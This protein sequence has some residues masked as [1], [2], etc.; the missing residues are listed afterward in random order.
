VFG[1]AAALLV[2]DLAVHPPGTPL[3][4][5]QHAWTGYLAYAVSFLT[6]GGCVAPADRPVRPIRL[7]RPAVPAA[8]PAPPAR[9]GL[10]P[11]VPARLAREALY[12]SGGER[13]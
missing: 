3:R 2:L 1:S 4:Q 5:A 10:P 13:V 11:A 7:G 8:Q 9:G 6:I 12:N